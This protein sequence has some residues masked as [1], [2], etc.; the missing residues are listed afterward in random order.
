ML[1]LKRLAQIEDADDPANDRPLPD[2]DILRASEA[3][4]SGTIDLDNLK[5]RTPEENGF[6]GHDMGPVDD[7]RH[8]ENSAAETEPDPS[9]PIR[10][11]SLE[12]LKGLSAEEIKKAFNDAGVR[13]VEEL[14][15]ARQRGQ[16]N[17][18]N[19]FDDDRFESG[20]SVG[21]KTDPDA[22][23]RENSSDGVRFEFADSFGQQAKADPGERSDDERVGPQGAS[24]DGS[25]ASTSRSSDHERQHAPE[26]DDQRKGSEETRQKDD[27]PPEFAA[28][29]RLR[30]LWQSLPPEMRGFLRFASPEK[31]LGA[32]GFADANQQTQPKSDPFINGGA[33][34]PASAVKQPIHDG[35]NEANNLGRSDPISTLL[36]APFN[37]IAGIASA[38]GG[39]G[40]RYIDH[41]AK[42]AAMKYEGISYENFRQRA[43]THFCHNETDAT[44]D[45]LRAGVNLG[46]A[47]EDYNGAFTNTDA[48]G[49][50][51]DLATARG[52]EMDDL[53]GRLRS[54]TVDPD[55]RELAREALKDPNVASAIGR[56]RSAEDAFVRAQNRLCDTVGRT[57]ETFQDMDHGDR[58]EGLRTASEEALSKVPD[59]MYEEESEKLKE[60]LKKLQEKAIELVRQILEAL[61]KLFTRG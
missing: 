46:Q 41:R 33:S 60:R 24:Q 10:F 37:A 49:R 12:K 39:L 50:M 56:M 6:D 23:M 40:K 38:V 32:A 28:D 31:G 11:D 57:I 34:S 25:T 27:I 42:L 8:A 61:K 3:A 43:Y 55:F 2:E 30:N 17:D 21:S 5:N 36:A 9:E 44:A 58:L 51:R 14:N 53:L 54:G 48:F 59:P 19:S 26:F 7:V 45:L 22:D 47:V 16:T 29:P 1:N 20:A 18:D 15:A 52:I 4:N 13:G 35:S